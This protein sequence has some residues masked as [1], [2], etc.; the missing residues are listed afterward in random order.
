MKVMKFGGG[1]LRDAGGF[2]KVAQ[3]LKKD[4]S[5]QNALVVSAVYGVTDELLF[6]TQTALESEERIL[7]LVNA[8]RDQHYNIIE[9]AIQN[10][11]LQKQ[12]QKDI[13]SHLRKLERH[14]YGVTYTGEITET[15]RI[16]IQSQGERISARILAAVLQDHGISAVA[17]ESDSIGVVADTVC[18]NATVDLDISGRNLREHIRPLL[19]KGIIPVITGFFGCTTNG[20]TTSF[21][22]NGS[23]YSASVIAQGLG[24]NSIHIWKD[25]DGFMTADP[26]IIES[27]TRIDTLSFREA[28]E[29]S[30]FGARV[31]HPRA[32]EPIAGTGIKIYIRNIQTESEPP[33]VIQAYGETRDDIIKSV[34]CNQDIAVL[35]VLGAGVGQKPGIIGTIGQTMSDA[36]IN[37]HSIL[38]SQTCINLL[39]DIGDAGRSVDA[40]RTLVGGVIENIELRADVALI[41]V[42]GEGLIATKGL[43]AAVSTAVAEQG[44]NIEMMAAGASEVAYYFIVK[45]SLMNRAI[46]AVHDR[47]FT[48]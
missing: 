9:E 35:K 47:Y 21:G 1:C 7:D 41:A 20:Q 2:K 27:A 40:L 4:R 43:A 33:T 48:N 30:Y 36:N 34:T 45:Q 5:S 10:P 17:L 3:I 13:E 32:V 18:E 46:Q 37:I 29:L 24:A 25:V 28:A 14:L 23:D 16:L 44:I 39:L 8:L 19:K 26:K 42:V 12:T 38:T 15:V 11:T 6:A 31:L 22:R